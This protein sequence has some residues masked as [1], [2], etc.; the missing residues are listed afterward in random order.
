MHDLRWIPIVVGANRRLA[1]SAMPDA[2]VIAASPPR[3]RRRLRGLAERIL[4]PRARRRAP[5]LGK[6]EPC[7]T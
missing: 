5:R 2:P 1:W 7:G 3:E 4:A 6:E